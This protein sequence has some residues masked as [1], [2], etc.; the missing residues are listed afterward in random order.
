MTLTT[1][2]RDALINVVKAKLALWDASLVAEALLHRDFGENVEIDTADRL[3]YLCA[4]LD[5]AADTEKVSDADL[6]EVFE[7]ETQTAR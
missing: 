4:G 5:T 1:E 7:L 6:I 3:D 2:Q